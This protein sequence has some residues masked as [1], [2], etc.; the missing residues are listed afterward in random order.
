MKLG[1]IPG[2]ILRIFLNTN[3]GSVGNKNFEFFSIDNAEAITITGQAAILYV[4]KRINEY[5]SSL[6]KLENVENFVIYI[7]TDSVYLSL[8][9]LVS[10]MF[11]DESDSLKITE[12]IS[13]F[14]EQKL[15]K[16][17]ETACSDFGNLMNS[18]EKVLEM[19]K[20]ETKNTSSK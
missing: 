4:E 13:K 20:V 3:D 18:R 11:T 2:N 5:L 17:I 19:K 15:S 8:D 6:L 14:C 1:K 7:D 16:I 12:F 9:K 10:K